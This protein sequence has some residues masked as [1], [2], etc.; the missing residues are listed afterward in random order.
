M[1]FQPATKTGHWATGLEIAF[2]L[3]M[4]GKFSRIGLPLPSFGIFG[5]GIAGFV[6]AIIALVRK[7]RAITVWLALIV[8]L[9]P[10][11]WTFGELLWPH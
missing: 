11:L 4:A 3:L 7:D 6:V 9:L 5:L 10:T 1:Q 2:L 8:G